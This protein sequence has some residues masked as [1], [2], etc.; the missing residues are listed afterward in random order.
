M[1]AS[2]IGPILCCRCIANVR[3]Q[4]GVIEH[5]E[6]IDLA[7]C[8]NLKVY[9]IKSFELPWWPCR[10][11][12]AY[13][14]EEPRGLI[15]TVELTIHSRDILVPKIRTLQGQSTWRRYMKSEKTLPEERSCSSNLLYMPVDHD[16]HYKPLHR[17]SRLSSPRLP[18]FYRYRLQLAYTSKR[19]SPKSLVHDCQSTRQIVCGPTSQLGPSRY[20][21]E[22][23]QPVDVSLSEQSRQGVFSV[24]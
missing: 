19:P 16:H 11:A 15:Q 13:F 17:N 9:R 23:H 12:L 24:R 22:P 14:V 7:F 8:E 1:S 21:S 6:C 10:S 5:L 18:D 20:F 2:R 4:S 3:S